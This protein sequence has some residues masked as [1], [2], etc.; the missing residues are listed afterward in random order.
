[1]KAAAAEQANIAQIIGSGAVG[2]GF[3]A[4]HSVFLDIGALEA[5]LPD[6]AP[7]A[8]DPF[9]G[10]ETSLNAAREGLAGAYRAAL[11]QITSLNA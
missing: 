1:L 5:R 2:Q 7:P 9:Y 11:E 10:F 4:E 3:E 6:A 8:H